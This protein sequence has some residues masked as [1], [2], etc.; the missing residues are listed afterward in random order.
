MNV[1]ITG[2]KV[3]ITA[4]IRRYIEKK[5]KKLDHYVDH[6]YDFIFTI[7]RE[8][9]IYFAEVNINVKKKIIHMFAKTEDVYSVIDILF[10]K[11][12]VK[13]QRYRDK[14]LNKRVIPLKESQPEILSQE[15]E[16]TAS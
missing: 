7:K 6:I 4:Q 3:K 11:I 13:L 9:H 15:L 12:E 2:R 16:E 8:R 14:L 5:L 1:S 10:D